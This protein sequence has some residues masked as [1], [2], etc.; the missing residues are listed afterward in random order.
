MFFAFLAVFA[1]SIGFAFV[2]HT[3]YTGYFAFLVVIAKLFFSRKKEVSEI[4]FKYSLVFPNLLKTIY[5]KTFF[6]IILIV[7]LS[8][9]PGNSIFTLFSNVIFAKIVLISCVIALIN[10]LIV[11]PILFIRKNPVVWTKWHVLFYSIDS[12]LWSCGIFPIL[13]QT[14]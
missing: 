12:I 2:C 6:Q 3:L 7:F 5:L 9:P 1:V 4:G 8:L 10:A 13:W 14:A 11:S